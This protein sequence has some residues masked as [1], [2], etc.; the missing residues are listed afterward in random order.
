M[1]YQIKFSSLNEFYA[2]LPPDELVVA[3]YL[4]DLVFR[5][6]PDAQERLSYNVPY[7]KRHRNICFIWPGSIAWGNKRTYDGV[8]F[9]FTKGYLLTDPDEYLAKGDRKQV[10]WREFVSIHDIDV[11]RLEALLHEAVLV[12]EQA[13]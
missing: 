1:P 3:E 4:R 2:F 11:S 8:R 10:Y 6:I 7:F 13:K 5:C 12:D 9:G